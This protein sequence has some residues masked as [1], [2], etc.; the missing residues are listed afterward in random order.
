MQ[1]NRKWNF[2][3]PHF[4]SFKPKLFSWFAGSLIEL[5]D[6]ITADILLPAS[7]VYRSHQQLWYQWKCHIFFFSLIYIFTWFFAD[8]SSSKFLSVW[9]F[10]WLFAPCWSGLT[11]RYIFYSYVG[12]QFHPHLVFMDRICTASIADCRVD[13]RL[14]RRTLFWFV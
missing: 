1:T 6:S 3:F 14:R 12:F 7:M 10:V 9:V 5:R 8:S 13:C 4:F 2:F 11:I